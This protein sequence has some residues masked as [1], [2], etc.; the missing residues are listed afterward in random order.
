MKSTLI[1]ALKKSTY[2][3]GKAVALVDDTTSLQYAALWEE[4]E[5]YSEK[6]S[7]QG[8]GDGQIIVLSF[9]NSIELAILFLALIN[10][11]AVPFIISDSQEESIDFVALNAFAY[12]VHKRNSSS[13]FHKKALEQNIADKEEKYYCFKN[14]FYKGDKA[15]STDAALL[16]TSSGSTSHS[17][18]IPLTADGILKNIQANAASL[19]LLPSDTTIVALPMNY[20]YGLIGQFLSHLYVG[21]KIIVVDTKFAITQIPRLIKLHKATSVFTAPPMIRQINYFYNKGFYREDFSSLRFVTVGGNHVERSSLLKA[22]KIFNC[23]FVKTY[24]LAE[25]GPRVS[26]NIIS[27]LT[28]DNIDSVG[29]AIEGVKIKIIDDK[30]KE[31]PAQ[32]QG[33]VVIQSPCIT[34]GYLNA[35]SSRITP[36]KQILTEDE[37]FV[38]A[39]GELTILGRRNENIEIKGRI[40][41]F[42]ELADVIYSTGQ[43]LKLSISKAVDHVA[44]EA[45]AIARCNITEES[46]YLILC[47]NF[48][49]DAWDKFRIKVLKANSIKV[50][51]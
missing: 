26:T 23:T 13:V 28:A 30:G 12:F 34:S 42:K 15:Y 51:K 21:S 27:S 22:M 8:I 36:A 38:S 19:G 5:V 49:I 40:Y 43:I 1:T 20:S 48:Q 44:I 6:L 37:G 17:K 2:N 3:T 9:P 50:V 41:W 24:G 33:R 31:L 11:G 45:V 10:V 4:V 39:E 29:K 16:V 7:Q 46:I 35:D 14:Q 32:S 47:E 25:A 18:L